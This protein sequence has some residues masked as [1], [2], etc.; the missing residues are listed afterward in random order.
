MLLL[1][2]PAPASRLRAVAQALLELD[3]ALRALPRASDAVDLPPGGVALLG[4]GREDL[5]WLNLNRPLFG[6]RRLRVVLWPEPEL[7]GVAGLRAGA[8]DFFDWISQVIALPDG[9]P[10]FAVAGLRA[11]A[12]ARPGVRWGGGDLDGALREAG[13]GSGLRLSARTAWPALIGAVSA[14][15]DGPIL[16]TEVGDPR[17]LWRV[18]WALAEAGFTGL[19][20]LDAPEVE[21]PGWVRVHGRAEP[22]REAATRLTAAGAKQG[23]LLAAL[24]DGEP[25]AVDRA[26]ERLRAGE[27]E[28]ALIA[29]G[30]RVE[31]EI[32]HGERA[33]GAYAEAL[34]QEAEQGLR[35]ERPDWADLARRAVR[36][37]VLDAARSWAERAVASAEPGID[38]ANALQALGVV[39]HAMGEPDEAEQVVARALTRQGQETGGEASVLVAPML[40][41]L[42]A[43]L[44]ALGDLPAAEAALRRIFGLRRSGEGDG[45]GPVLNAPLRALTG[46]LLGRGNFEGARALF[47]NVMA[48][49][50]EL[51]GSEVL[52]DVAPTMRGLAQVLEVQG[53]LSTARYLLERVIE[54]EVE[55]FGTDL[56][57]EVAVAL[58][59]LGR[60]L[61]I[62]GDLYG[63]KRKFERALDI[64]THVFGTDGHPAIAETRH[65]LAILLRDQGDLEGA[66]AQIDQSLAIN[67]SVFGPDHPHV[68]ATLLT[69]ATIL[70]AQGAVASAA[71]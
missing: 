41:E 68:A 51:R 33:V 2:H 6:Q 70:R 40:L 18:R 56:H 26:V 65:D 31:P 30:W 37:G 14:A 45:R 16:W 39:L 67:T 55:D 44:H 4:V 52:P 47:R 54:I 21:A 71:P 8:P 63:A 3:P 7:G 48:R 32:P 5:G 20:I 28:G 42:G 19:S 29:G 60:A 59:Q 69:L 38:L 22:W 53:D 13:L 66:R 17:D 64:Q 10:G 24:L 49:C 43:G 12:G 61:Q 62:Q 36:L 15:G 1:V 50:A 25:E 34:V 35:A 57:P 9:P 27:D 46:L 11:A 58:R 23:G